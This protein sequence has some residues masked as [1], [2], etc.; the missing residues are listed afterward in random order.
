[1][2]DNKAWL[3]QVGVNFEIAIANGDYVD[4][5][6]LIALVRGEGFDVEAKEMENALVEEKLGTFLYPAN[7]QQWK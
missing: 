3:E 1:M 2:E 4:C 6:E 7:E 5:K